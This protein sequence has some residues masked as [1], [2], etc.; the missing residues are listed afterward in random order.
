MLVWRPVEWLSVRR[1]TRTIG[2]VAAVI[3]VVMLH[4]GAKHHSVA[5]HFVGSPARV[6]PVTVAAVAD[7]VLDGIGAIVDED[8]LGNVGWAGGR[9]A[10]VGGGIV[11][12]VG[13][14]K[15]AHGIGATGKGSGAFSRFT[16]DG[17]VCGAGI[18]R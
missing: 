2:A 16:C 14:L 9:F 11:F 1:V 17:G 8:G 10:G 13:G 12:R 3:I 4:Q 6:V 18:P 15:I 7:V 5:H